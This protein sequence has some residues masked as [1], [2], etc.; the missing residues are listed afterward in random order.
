M[1]ATQTATVASGTVLERTNV[2]RLIATIT[3]GLLVLLVVGVIAGG[4][5]LRM[6]LAPAFDRQITIGAGH[7]LA[8]HNGPN[9]R[10]CPTVPPQVDC[11]WRVP[12]QREFYIRYITPQDSWLLISF[13]LPDR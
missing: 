6:G 11:A 8:V 10:S 5:A 3:K 7:Y 9:G 1:N 2:E 4:G 12:G 13:R